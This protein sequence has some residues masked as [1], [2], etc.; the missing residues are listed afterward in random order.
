VVWVAKAIIDV[1]VRYSE[2]FIFL[3]HFSGFKNIDARVL[4][5][6]CDHYD[7]NYIKNEYSEIKIEVKLYDW[8]LVVST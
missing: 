2:V 3:P 8:D 5:A 1:P 7:I 4:L 6:D